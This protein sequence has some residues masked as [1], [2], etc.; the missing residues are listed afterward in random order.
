MGEGSAD[1]F[2]DFATLWVVVD[3]LGSLP[4]LMTLAGRETGRTRHR[5]AIEAVVIAFLVLAAFAL[6]G[7]WV[8]QGL[9]IDLVSF[10]IAGGI[11][12]MI[13]ALM[14]IFGGDKHEMDLASYDSVDQA[15]AFPLAIPSLASPGAMLLVVLLAENEGRTVPVVTLGLLAAALLTALAILLLAGPLHRL[16]GDAG[17]AVI[18]RVMGLILAAVATDEVLRALETLGLVSGIS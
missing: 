17:A 6:F 3:P 4:V 7:L 5:L 11:V 8:L 1:L 10:R 13:F 2:Q 12:L 16:I 9:G 18:S 15:A 14:L